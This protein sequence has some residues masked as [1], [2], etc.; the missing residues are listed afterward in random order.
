VLLLAAG[1]GRRQ[2]RA[3]KCSNLKRVR[4]GGGVGWRED[5]DD[6][7]GCGRFS[8]GGGGGFGCDDGGVQLWGV[9][10]NRLS[11]LIDLEV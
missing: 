6:W 10:V 1:L 11:L 7:D 9:R 2:L 5:D 3:G 4:V 8:G